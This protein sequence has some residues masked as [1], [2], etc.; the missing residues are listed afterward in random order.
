M[1]DT[2]EV[3]LEVIRSLRDVVPA[4]EQFDRDLGDQMRRAAT[5]VTLNLGEG[6][7]SS[8]GN[9]RKH[10]QIAHGS[11][12]EVK[13]CLD[14]TE[15]WGWPIE[16]TAARA[17]IDRQLALLWRLTHGKAI[18]TQKGVPLDPADRVSGSRGR[19]TA[20]ASA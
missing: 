10:Y 14:V 8:K 2:Y 9:Q 18:K 20:P 11:A 17:I 5:S 15:A 4:V 16:T 12:N 13:A 3:S 6:Q 7:R 19:S 1:F